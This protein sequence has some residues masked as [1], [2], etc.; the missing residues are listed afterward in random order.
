[1]RNGWIL[2]ALPL[3]LAIAAAGC[4]NDPV[5]PGVGSGRLL[6]VKIDGTT[7]SLTPETLF[8]SYDD[9]LDYGTFGAIIRLGGGPPEVVRND[10]KV[11]E[12]Y[13]GTSD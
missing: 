8:S 11:I 13:L 1:M 4:E 5:G 3:L 6:E 9:Q 10:P 12:A 2:M 7:H